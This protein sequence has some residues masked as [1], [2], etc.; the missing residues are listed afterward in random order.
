MT[1][2]LQAPDE[3]E[4][5]LWH[6]F[7]FEGP[8]S[9]LRAKRCLDRWQERGLSL[10]EVLNRLPDQCRD[11]GL[12]WE[13]ARQLQPPRSPASV[14]ALRWNSPHYPDGLRDL[15]LKRRPALLFTRGN[16]ELLARPM[17]TFVPGRPNEDELAMLREA[18][19]ALMGEN[20]LLTA[21]AD[22][23]Q[24]ALLIEEMAYSDGEIMIVPTSG[25][26]NTEISAVETRYIEAGRLVLATPLPPTMA[27][28][29]VLEPLL[30][31]ITSAAASRRILS[32]ASDTYDAG[33]PPR[34]TLVLTPTPPP[35][36]ESPR[37]QFTDNAADVLLWVQDPEQDLTG[38]PLPSAEPRDKPTGTPLSPEETL[39]LLEQG[40][41]VPPALR[42]RLTD[43]QGS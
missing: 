31:Q 29:P 14:Q 37:L 25:L 8:L 22:T 7:V 33:T 6:W 21:L 20:L 12:T 38:G 36:S 30:Q 34:P 23:V 3:R 26:D 1:T 18:V 39:S 42:A 24:A 9:T 40:G 32:T 10:I 41:D 16:V 13:E 27:A 19:G 28:D 2:P 35:A 4:T 17:I 11:V 43:T 5:T 15:S